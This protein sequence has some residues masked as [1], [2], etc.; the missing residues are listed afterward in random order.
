MSE[1]QERKPGHEDN[2]GRRGVH[3]HGYNTL[4][5]VA[6]EHQH[7]IMGV[8]AP[9][10]LAEGSHIHRVRGRTSFHVDHWHWYDVLSGP[11]VAM[12]GGQHIHY[13]AGETSFDDNHTHDYSGVLGLSPDVM[14]DDCDDDKYYMMKPKYPKRD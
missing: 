5:E 7:V 11:A 13:F 3:V 2:E 8:S 10:R 6:D 1:E 14:D 12:P 4:T 9:A